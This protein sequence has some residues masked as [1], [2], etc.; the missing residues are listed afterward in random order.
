MASLGHHK[1]AGKGALTRFSTFATIPVNR[2]QIPQ[3]VTRLL[4]P[5]PR[6]LTGYGHSAVLAGRGK[7]AKIGPDRVVAREARILGQHGGRLPLEVPT[8]IAAGF[9]WLVMQEV[10]DVA[11]RW[12]E[13]EY[14]DL[15]VD[16]AALHDA[17]EESPVLAGGWLR[18][19]SRRDLQATLTE[20]DRSGVELPAALEQAA[21]D[22]AVVAQI[23]A[24]S[25]PVTLVHSTPANI[26]RPGPASQRVWVDW[27][28]ASKA[29]AAVD[30]ACWLNQWPWQF[31]RRYGRERCIETYLKARRRAV[32]S[33]E[34][35]HAL[36]AALVLF[37]F[38]NN[39][40]GLA[41]EVGPGAL[42]ALIGEG[43]EA[44]Q[45]LGFPS[46]TA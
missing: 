9:G 17:F 28:W 33:R 7:V 27:E 36:D 18:D 2:V 1:R 11:S 22:P 45:R 14:T 25:R 39:L 3:E 4:G 34:L 20:G 30:L 40:P 23:L 35:E 31:G 46:R 44:L 26:R 21:N 37:F 38:A 16:L 5:A 10:P 8:L 29:S 19:P 42:E 13:R 32:D 43:S 24:A 41:R 6:R 12:D 15:L